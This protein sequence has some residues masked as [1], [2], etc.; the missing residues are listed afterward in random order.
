MFN[1]RLAPLAEGPATTAGLLAQVIRKMLVNPIPGP[2][3]G[4]IQNLGLGT[5]LV[6]LRLVTLRAGKMEICPT[7]RKPRE[8]RL[9]LAMFNVLECHNPDRHLAVTA[10]VPIHGI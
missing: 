6:P 1:R 8:S 7:E 5:P 3:R 4:G 9:G 10:K 2:T